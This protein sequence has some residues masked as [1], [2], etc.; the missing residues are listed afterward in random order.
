MKVCMV[1]SPVS[2]RLLQL[3]KEIPDL[4]GAARALDSS[5]ACTASA[6]TSGTP[7]QKRKL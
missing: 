3:W 5:R 7:E 6:G 1:A 4:G 2:I